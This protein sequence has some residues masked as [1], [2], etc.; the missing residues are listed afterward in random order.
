MFPDI[1]NAVIGTIDWYNVDSS[2]RKAQYIY[3]THSLE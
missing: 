2:Q 3:K 1:I